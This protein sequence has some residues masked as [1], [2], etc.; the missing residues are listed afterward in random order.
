MDL[1]DVREV[2]LPATRAEVVPRPGEA[3]LGGGTWLFSEPQPG[4]RGLVDVTAA[5][6]EPWTVTPEGLTVGASCTLAELAAVPRRPDWTAQPVFATA[7]DALLGSWKIHRVATVGGNLC[8]ALPAGPMTALTAALDGTAVVWRPDGDDRRVPVL[9]LVTGVRQTSLGAG[10]VLRAVELPMHALRAR[11][12]SRR[13]SLS[14]LG[15]SAAFVLARRDADGAFVV[16]VTASTD[17]PRQVRFESVPSA[18]EIT[19]ALDDLGDWYDDPHGDPR[20]RR[21]TTLRFGRELR[22]ELAGS[23]EAGR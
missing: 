21:A 20:W 1:V 12:A 8:L 23:P 17:R 22:D 13:A 9:D 15:R 6:W 3:V 10:E 19:D 11:V 16:T 5:G 2:R 7:V 4:V 14:A 18:A